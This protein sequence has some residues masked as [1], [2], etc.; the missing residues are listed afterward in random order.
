MSKS[1]YVLTLSCQNRP[2]IVAA[3][4]TYLFEQGADIREAQ[5]F[6]DAETNRF[7]ARIGFDLLGPSGI[8][9]LREGFATVAAPFSLDWTLN[10]HTTPRRVLLLVSK[11]DHCLADLLYLTSDIFPVHVEPVAVR[12]L[13]RGR[14]AIELS[15]QDVGEGFG[16]RRG[17]VFEEVGNADRDRPALQA[18]LTVGI[19][20]LF[21]FHGD[22]GERRAGA[23]FPEHP[24]EDLFRGF[25]E[26]GARQIDRFETILLCASLSRDRVEHNH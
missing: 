19:G 15:Q 1:Q 16:Y 14:V 2:G 3:V 5:Q 25:E 26:Q 4:S 18:N 21:V 9:A 6:D 22:R 23:Q 11:F 20:E 17:C 13:A 12:V 8:A 10:D 24:F 7:F